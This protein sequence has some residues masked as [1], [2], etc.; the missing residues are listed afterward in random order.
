MSIPAPVILL[1]TNGAN[2]ATDIV[3]QTLSGT[4]STDTQEIHVNGSTAGVSYTAGEE[5]WSWTGDLSNGDNAISIVAYERVT[6]TPSPAVFITITLVQ[7]DSFITV[8]P[9]TGVKLRRYQDKV[10]VVTSK[11]PEPQVLGYNFYV[12]TRS[13]GINNAYAM[14]NTTLITDYS[15]HEQKT[16]VLSS[17]VDTVSNI[18]VTTTTEEIDDIYYYSSILDETRFNELVSQGSIDPVIF[19]QDTPLF[20][21]VSAVIYDSVSGQVTESAYSAEMQGSPIVITTGIKDLPARSQ[22]DIILTLSGELLSTNKGVDTKPGTVVRDMMNPTSE[23]MARVYI[24]QDFLSRALSVSALMDFDDADGD[25]V[26]DP[27][28]SSVKK[29]KLQLALNLQNS[30]DVQTLIDEQFDKLASNV[31]V[32]RKGAVPST[33]QVTFYVTNPPIRDMYVYEGAVVATLGDL[34]AGIA[35]QNYRVLVSKLLEAASRDYFYNTATRRYELTADVEAVAAGTAGNTDSYTVRTINSGVDSDFLVENP[36]PISFGLEEETNHDLGGRIQLAMFTDTGTEGGYVR[37]AIAVPGVRNVRVEK[38]KDPLMIRDW[39]PLRKEH[40]GGKVDL[41]VQGERAKQVSDQV[42]FAFGSIAAQ[43]QQTG[44]TFQILSVAA[45]QFQSTNPSVTAHTPIFDVTRV[46]NATRGQDYDISGFKIIGDGNVVDLNEALATNVAIGLASSDIIRVDYK[47]RGSDTFIMKN[48]PVT[49]V[50]SVKGQLSGVLPSTAYEIVKLEDPLANGNST[51]AKDGVRILEVPSSAGIQPIAD[52]EHVMILAKEEPLLYLGVDP[53]SIVVKNEDKTVTY[54]ESVDY[55]VTP[56]TDTEPTTLLIIESGSMTNG[57]LVLISYTAIENF[58]ITYSTNALL[59]DVQTE[60]DAMKHACADA[61]VKQA[62]ENAVDFSMTIV[63]KTGVTNL[64]FL[65][66]RIR[67]AVANYVSQLD[68]GS[69]MTQSEIVRIIQGV[70]DVESIVLPF[71]RMVKA[72]GS[73]IARDDLGRLEFQVFNEATVKSYVT[74]AVVLTYKTVDQGGPSN[75]FRGVFENGE[76]L[77]LQTDPIDVS[78]GAGRA[79]IRSDGKIVVSTKDGQLPDDKKYSVAYYVYGE[80][81]A[82]DI[83]VAS[84]EYLTVGN[85]TVVYDQPQTQVQV[86]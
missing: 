31:N 47:Y 82:K 75:L 20:F 69:S 48:Q 4:T 3:T 68:V 57:E 38:A 81:G 15:S 35:A 64:N 43:G 27:V 19:S 6:L 28:A 44:E 74:S 65:T 79:Y 16:R 78:D 33:G 2:Y 46:H 76:A 9:P 40:V 73:F 55:R 22:N 85:F 7:S 34:D 84:L 10:E 54:I 86:L 60:V 29:S 50:I 51:I 72:D 17:T 80:T 36:N 32:L 58:L 23:E 1:P 56:G 67:T 37:T 18:R 5:A 59:G 77:V 45:F 63:P 39:E 26:S 8:S 30:S 41:Y 71:S 53:E 62:V 14:I 24:I 42:A 66:S 11:N 25:G 21:V 13:G 61:I 49:S 83:N 12:S 70:S 52:E